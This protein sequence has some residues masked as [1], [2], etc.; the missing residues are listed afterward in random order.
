MSKEEKEFINELIEE[1]DR[2]ALIECT[3]C[4][5]CMPCPK[6]VNIVKCFE[7]YNYQ[8]SGAFDATI[9]FKADY[10]NLIEKGADSSKCTKCGACEK[11]CPQKIKII[12]RLDEI[13]KIF[14]EEN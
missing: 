7:A 5:Y 9:R 11:V 10:K 6:G 12:K 3:K 13:G 4:E 8:L 14:K 2:K 1:W